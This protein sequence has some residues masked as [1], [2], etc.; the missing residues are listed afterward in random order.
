MLN[1]KPFDTYLRDRVLS[2]L[3]MNDT[4][5]SREQVLGELS[6][7][8]A[9]G[10]QH[11]LDV[12]MAYAAWEKVKD[13]NGTFD[14]GSRVPDEMFGTKRAYRFLTRSKRYGP[15]AGHVITTPADMVS[16]GTFALCAAGR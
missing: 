8:Y 7:R 6:A 3:G 14:L 15:G 12:P 4:V 1:G 2:K 10:W 16:A 9:D 11:E 13:E 5:P